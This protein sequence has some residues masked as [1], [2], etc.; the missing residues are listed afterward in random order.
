MQNSLT[1]NQTPWQL[2]TDLDKRSALAR[3][4]AGM[5]VE[6]VYN[7][8]ADDYA[9]SVA[10]EGVTA[11]GLHT[12]VENILRGSLGHG[13]MPKPPVL[14]LEIDKV[15]QPLNEE[16]A[17]N[18]RDRRVIEEMD[19]TKPSGVITNNTEGRTL[20]DTNVTL[21]EFRRKGMTYGVGTLY[22]ARTGEVWSAVDKSRLKPVTQSKQKVFMKW[23]ALKAKNAAKASS[24]G[25]GVSRTADDSR[26]WL[27]AQIGQ[28]EFD[29]IPDLGTGPFAKL[30]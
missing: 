1:T 22:V 27:I 24:A 5:Q 16:R 30:K 8:Q 4:S 21:D 19:S 13:F 28:D 14:R 20:I 9:Y 17:R 18:A 2:A 23:E 7:Q 11:Y 10:L 3:L 26:N 15:M 25:D 6:R 12:A 29:K